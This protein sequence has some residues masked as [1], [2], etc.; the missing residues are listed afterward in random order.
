MRSIYDNVAVGGAAVIFASTSG[1][2]VTGPTVDTKGYNT[3]A[4]RLSTTAVGGAA[5]V[6]ATR[7]T[8]AAIVQ[9]SDDNSSWSTATSV[10]GT[11]IGSTV[12]AIGT[13]GN[14]TSVR[15]EGLGVSN[16]KRYIRV[17]LTTGFGPIATTA[18]IFT[19]AAIFELGRGY[20]KPPTTDYSPT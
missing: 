1:V 16:C 17:Q 3:A 9:E 5:N 15:I 4:L 14:V 19:L 7:G 2:V 6:V 10:D 13:N 18:A 8:V 20:N 11:T 12:A